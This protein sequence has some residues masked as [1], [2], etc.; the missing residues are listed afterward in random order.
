MSKG[1]LAINP[2]VVASKPFITSSLALY[3]VGINIHQ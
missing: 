2:K 1:L 3:I